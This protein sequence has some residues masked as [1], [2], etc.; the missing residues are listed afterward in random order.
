MRKLKEPSKILVISKVRTRV[1]LLRR[2]MIDSGVEYHCDICKLKEW[3]GKNIVIEVHHIDG[4]NL[5]NKLDN[6]QFLCPNCHSQTDNFRVKNI[7]PTNI[8]PLKNQCYCGN[9]KQVGS[10]LCRACNNK[11]PKARKVIR[12]SKE[13]LQVD[14]EELKYNYSAVGRKYGVSDNAIRK[15]RKW[16]K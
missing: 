16:Y 2:A 1:N 11:L 3:Q 14:L 15:W 6:L 5:N 4:D 9:L 7:E 13:Q 12:P 10:L 8:E